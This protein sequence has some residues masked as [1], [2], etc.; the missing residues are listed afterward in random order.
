MDNNNLIDYRA[1]WEPWT[2]SGPDCQSIVN[3][4]EYFVGQGSKI[5]KYNGQD[6]EP[7]TGFVK[8]PQNSLKFVINLSINA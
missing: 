3:F 1:Y 4:Y 8:I 6:I 7:G 2:G 5:V